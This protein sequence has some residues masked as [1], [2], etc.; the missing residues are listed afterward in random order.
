[1]V[2]LHVGFSQEKLGKPKRI[3]LLRLGDGEIN[4]LKFLFEVP[5]M[6]FF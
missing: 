6:S 2:T 1:M 3:F 5:S 4:A